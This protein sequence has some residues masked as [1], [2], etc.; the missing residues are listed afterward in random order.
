MAFSG[1]FFAWPYHAGVAAFIQERGLLDDDSR[2]YG[3]S[4]GAVVAVM[5]ACGVDIARVGTPAALEA[6]A[7]AHHRI[8]VFRSRNVIETYFAIFG[9]TLPDDAHRRATGRLHVSVT[10]VPSIRRRLVAEFP[11]R[12]ALLDSLAASL[13][14]PGLTVPLAYRLPRFGWCVDGHS[15]PVDNRPGV[16]TLRVG[17]RPSSTNRYDIQPSRP[18]GWQQMFLVQPAAARLSLFDLGYADARRHLEAA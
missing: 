8:P 15:V 6:N 9:R 10:Q 7:R 12:Q 1:A 16:R 17:V 2:I 13:A 14:V 4:S 3:A 18:I 5:L 11:T